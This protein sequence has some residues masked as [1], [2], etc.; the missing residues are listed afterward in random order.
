[1][2]IKSKNYLGEVLITFGIITFMTIILFSEFWNP[3]TTLTKD[4]TIVWNML[5]TILVLWPCVM[6]GHTLRFWMS[7]GKTIELNKAGC[8][9]SFLLYHREYKWEELK[10]KRYINYSGLLRGRY[11][12]PYTLGAE[13]S[14]NIIPKN[15]RWH[16]VVHCKLINP[17]KYIYICFPPSETN[18]HSKGYIHAY[19]IDEVEFKNKIAKWGITLEEIN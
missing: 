13:F 15:K 18:S 17:L 1:M 6:Y 14:P 3:P 5:R 12:I 9:V 19:E 4:P 11:Y 10:V 2:I 16:P 7:I 8:K